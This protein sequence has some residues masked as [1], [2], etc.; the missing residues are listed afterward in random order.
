MSDTVD[1]D[2]AFPQ[3]VLDANP[4]MPQM[5]DV[6]IA[7]PAGSLFAD[8]GTVGGQVGLAPVDRNR[9]PGTLPADLRIPLVITVQVA[10]ADPGDPI[11]TNFDI[12]APVVF[13]NLPDPDTLEV[14]APGEKTAIWS[15]DHDTGRWR[16]VGPA[17]VSADG[18]TVSSDPGVGIIALGWHGVAPG[19]GL[20]LEEARKR[21]RDNCANAQ[22][23]A[24]EDCALTALAGPA[25]SAVGLPGC[26]SG[27]LSAG[28]TAARDCSNQPG[29]R[30]CALM[31]A[32]SA[33]L[34]CASVMK[35]LPVIGW[36][37][38]YGGA[39]KDIYENCQCDDDPGDPPQPDDE[40]DRN[41]DVMDAMKDYGDT[42]TG[43]PTWTEAVDPVSNPV[44]PGAPPP[45][46]P[47]NPDLLIDLV[48]TALSEP[49]DEGS[50]ISPS[51]D[52][53]FTGCRCHLLSRRSM[54]MHL[55]RAST[56]APTS[57][58]R[59]STRTPPQGAT[60]LW[61]EIRSSRHWIG[62]LPQSMHFRVSV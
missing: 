14:L 20:T 2:V 4:T 44:F 13:P 34:G 35:K 47:G 9:L 51:E 55:S 30:G 38:T 42:V 45:L 54:L 33:G 29:G 52:A 16:L 8:N 59:G 25:G 27:F 28:Y 57:G 21:C 32:S 10:G 23:G 7:I 48:D 56:I 62:S 41:L 19:T 31:K 1:T 40:F 18:L 15:F 46:A 39:A 61:T 58:S 26:V 12:P 17:T 6:R 22:R 11:P 3:A 24:A 49:S 5:A 60:T 36:I 37:L 53:F 43:N 50:R